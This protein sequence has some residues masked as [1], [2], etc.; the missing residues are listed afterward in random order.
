[1][2][3]RRNFNPHSYYHVIMRGNNREAIFKSHEDMVEL[4]RALLHVYDRYPFTVLAYCFMSNHYH[5]LIKPTKDQLSKIMA[6]INRRYSDSY[7]KRYNHVGRIYQKRYFAK[8]VRS[9]KGLLVVSS[10][11]HRNPIDTKKPMVDRLETYPY[12]SYPFYFHEIKE[13]PRFLDRNLLKDLLP[14]PMEKTNQAYC[15]YCLESR[16]LVEEDIK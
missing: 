4:M 11:I 14:P 6:L 2:T 16:E 10:Y 8:E 5:I 15:Q 9:R 3:R 1:M 13:S 7:S 12:S